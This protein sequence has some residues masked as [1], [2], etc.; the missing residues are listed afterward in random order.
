[1][2][3]IAGAEKI[4]IRD[5]EGAV[6]EE[7]M[8]KDGV[9]EGE[10]VL[11]ASGRLRARLQFEQGL[12]GGESLFYD[13]AGE[14][15]TRAAYRKG[16]LNGDS[17]YYGADGKLV[18]KSAYQNGV[19]SGYTVDYYPSGKPRQVATYRDNLLDGDMVR[20]DEGG[21]VLERLHYKKG[22]LQPPPPAVF[23]DVKLPGRKA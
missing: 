22:R 17:F 16:K 12:Q 14:V 21:K 1:M 7:A 23:K 6:T 19:L 13:D 9:L 20:L 3:E 8:M 2:P 4:V 18:R 15:T 10:T 11:Y 5:A